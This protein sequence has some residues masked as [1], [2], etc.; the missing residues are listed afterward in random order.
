MLELDPLPPGPVL[1]PRM[2][3]F[4]KDSGEKDY[5]RKELEGKKHSP[6]KKE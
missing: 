2:R 4:G 3:G 5:Y 6:P 1:T